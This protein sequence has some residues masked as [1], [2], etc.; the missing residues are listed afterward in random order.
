MIGQQLSAHFTLREFTR[1][2]MAARL[3]I[4]NTPSPAVIDRLCETAAMLEKVRAFLSSRL[5]APVPIS[6]TSGYRCLRLNRALKSKDT[7]H[8]VL[9]WA[10]DFT[11]SAYGEPYHVA[12]LLSANLEVLSIGQVI[13]EY[14][15]WIHISCRPPQ[16]LVNR[17]LTIDRQG[18]HLG[19]I[20]P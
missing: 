15:D 20:E 7:S 5:Q 19:I 10:A 6:I 3:G 2:T 14:G 11:A 16:R 17:V 9:G 12:R 18:T 13:L 4:D 1:S 8:H